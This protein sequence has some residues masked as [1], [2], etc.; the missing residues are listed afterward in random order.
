MDKEKIQGILILLAIFGLPAIYVIFLRLNMRLLLDIAEREV[1][2]SKAL[3]FLK[4][5]VVSEV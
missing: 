2:L 4:V 5:K 1:L 3:I